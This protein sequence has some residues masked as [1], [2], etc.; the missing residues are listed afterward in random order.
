MLI[1]TSLRTNKQAV[2]Q[3]L[4]DLVTSIQIGPANNQL[5]VATYDRRIRPVFHLSSHID[6]TELL[7]AVG[8]LQFHHEETRVDERDIVE[9]LHNHL[10]PGRYGDRDL[11]KN[12]IIVLTDHHFDRR[13]DL[14]RSSYGSLHSV[15]QDVIVIHVGSS[16]HLLSSLAT[17]PNHVINVMGYSELLSILP[18][19]LELLC[20]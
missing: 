8:G 6:Q 2:I 11:Y 3:F 4:K 16:I 14:P 12:V 7:T 13:R 19:V 17:D 10:Q 5:G 1:Q 18:R 15:S 9:F 20:A